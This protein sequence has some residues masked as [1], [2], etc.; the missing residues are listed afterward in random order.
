MHQSLFV[1]AAFLGIACFVVNF[2]TRMW[3]P[4]RRY[5]LLLAGNALVI[6]AGTQD[7]WW[8]IG[9][10]EDSRDI[11]LLVAV[12][13]MVIAR[14]KKD[15]AA[16]AKDVAT[17]SG[18]AET[19]EPPMITLIALAITVMF[20]VRSLGHPH[21]QLRMALLGSLLLT[22]GGALYSHRVQNKP[23]RQMLMAL[24]WVTL[25]LAVLVR[26]GHSLWISSLLS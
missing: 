20:F 2:F 25:V 22:I 26:F 8:H 4:M 16:G 24:S 1:I 17:A 9:E 6:F 10:W 18:A 13:A 19:A 3:P 12:N 23:A 11:I 7:P 21:G 15:S 14:I 5:G